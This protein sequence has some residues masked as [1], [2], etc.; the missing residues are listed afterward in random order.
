[1]HATAVTSSDCIVRGFK[2]PLWNPMGL[3]MGMVLGFK[4]PRQPIL[5]MVF[6][7]EIETIGS[8]V[9]SFNEGDRVFGWDLVPNFGT[10]AEY[11][12]ISEN[13]IM[14]I[15]PDNLSYEDA[16][17]IPYGG[18]LA[19]YFLRKGNIQA[20]RKVM[21][22]GASG[23]VGTSAVQIARY[24]GAEVIGVCGP[25]NLEMVKSLGAEK[26]LD[27]TKDDLTK[28]EEYFN[29]VLDAVG[30]K[31][32][33][34]FF[35][36]QYLAP[37]GKFISVDKGSPKIQVEDLHYL[38]KLVESGDLKAVIDRSYPLEEIVEA[39]RYVDQGHKKGNVIIT[40]N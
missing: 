33:A 29:L 5:G 21:I 16:A 2:I 18:L 15:M 7:G 12:C 11:K 38:V 22:Y 6:A 32:S 23:A 3:M 36:E 35:G 34:N 1:M 4:K 40:I 20:C 25:T 14:D 19:L 31:K 9:M 28:T 30:K 8:Q 26:V 13:G 10:Y 37:Y 39:H 17:A 27:Y 24:F